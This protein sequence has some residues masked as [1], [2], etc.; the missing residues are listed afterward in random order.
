MSSTAKGVN[1]IYDASGNIA[2]DLDQDGLADDGTTDTNQPDHRYLIEYNDSPSA[3]KLTETGERIV[4]N[5][6]KY[7]PQSD[8][9]YT[10]PDINNVFLAYVAKVRDQNGVPHQVVKPS[11]MAP[12]LLRSPI[13]GVSAPLTFEDTNFNGELDSGEDTNSNGVLDDWCVNPNTAS[14]VMRG[15][16]KHIFVPSSGIPNS[17]SLRYMNDADAVTYIGGTARGFPFHPMAPN[18]NTATGTPGA[19]YLPGRMGPYS[20]LSATFNSDAPIEFDYDNDGD[21]LREAILMDLDFPP[22]KDSSGKLFVPLY[23]VTI[24]DLDALINLNAHGNLAKLLYGPNDE[25]LA[26]VPFSNTSPDPNS[27]TDTLPLGNDNSPTA[28]KFWYLS[29]SNLGLGPSEINPLWALNARFGTDNAPASTVFSQHQLFYG[30]TPRALATPYPA[31]GET[32]NMELAW[33]KLGRLDIDGTGPTIKDVLPGAYGE[34]SRLYNA[35]ATNNLALAGG[36]YLPRPGISLTDDNADIGEGQSIPPF[37]QHP[38]DYTGLGSY[39]TNGKLLNWNTASAPFQWLT[40]NKYGNNINS[41]TGNILWG[42]KAGLMTNSLTQALGDDPNEIPFYTS[43]QYD[44]LFTSDEMLYLSLKNSEIT[45]L[46]APSRLAQLLPFNFAKDSTDNLRGFD[47]RRKFTTDSNDRKSFGL[48]FTT[49]AVNDYSQDF[50]R[51]GGSY[52]GTYRFPPQFGNTATAVARYTTTA[53]AE[54][55]FRPITRTLLEIELNNSRNNNHLQRKLSINHFLK[56]DTNNQI[57]FS[58]L[59]PHPDDPGA[60]TITVASY[61]PTTPAGQEYWARSDRQKM[62]RDIYV[63]LYL[64]GHGDDSKN[65]AATANVNNALYTDDQLREMAQFAVNY[66]D[67]LDRDNVMTRFEYDKDLSD[68]WNLDD[69][70]YGAIE[71]GA[72]PYT[73]AAA[74]YNPSY[75]NDSAIRGE[76]FGIERLDLVLN[77]SLFIA[78]VGGTNYPQTNYDETTDRHFVYAEVVNQGP[79]P[80]TF[81]TK[82]AYQIVLRQEG[83]TPWERAATIKDGTVINSGATVVIGSTDTRTT[84]SAPATFKRSTFAVNSTNSGP[85]VAPPVAPNKPSGSPNPDCDTDLVELALASLP[86]APT[87]MQIL[88]QAGTDVS[89][90]PGAM[91]SA[92]TGA[93]PAGDLTKPIKVLLRRRAHPTRSISTAANDNPWVE[94][95]SIILQPSL[96]IQTF[97]LSGGTSATNIQNQLKT[98]K[99]LERK[100]PLD[101]QSETPFSDSTG[102]LTTLNSLG[103]T[104]SVSLTAFNLWQR[105]FDRDFSSIIDLMHIPVCAPFQFTALSYR[106]QTESPATQMLPGNAV[107]SPKWQSGAPLAQYSINAK[108]AAARFMV[109]ED[110][111]NSTSLVSVNKNNRWHRVLE[112]LEVPTRTNLNLG[113]G[114]ALSIPRVPGRINLNTL[115]HPDNL[116]ALLD[117]STAMSLNLGSSSPPDPEAASLD[118]PS[119]S[120]RD[121]WHQLLRSRDPVDPYAATAGAMIDV[122]LPGLPNPNTIL[123]TPPSTYLPDAKP[124]KS[125]ADVPVTPSP[126]S[127]GQTHPTVSGT[128][129]ATLPLDSA[130]PIGAQRRL[131]EIGSQ[132]EHISSTYDPYVQHRLLSKIVGNSTTRSNCFAIFI[133]VKYFQAAEVNGAVRIAGP[134]NGTPEPEHRGLFVI[135][136]S[137]L[138]A[139]QQSNGPNYNFRAFINYRKTL[140]TQ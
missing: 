90:T 41:A 133:S 132:A 91:L 44:N 136:R 48:P 63:L 110:P 46:N 81:D 129:L 96:G 28:P 80:V 10:Y 107:P 124:F 51:V 40:Y 113:V 84:A 72:T 67:A 24:H 66:V 98:V 18:Y 120:T 43:T 103:K 12:G 140:Q 138:E 26:D 60:A 94:I 127:P 126:A 7:F 32:A 62:A 89:A 20:S 85:P 39:T 97:D 92:F 109:P 86:T 38:L 111:I 68:G 49:R 19:V 35:K 21:G 83:T 54:D 118:D 76:V 34:E 3:P 8:V 77:E 52:T 23:L 88:D 87:T 65:T 112:F 130:Q 99:S 105:H 93:A 27:P 6:S 106:M 102:A 117:D 119:E 17:P 101:S 139:G 64:L 137:K 56:T 82:G 53:L 75:P 9:G 45:R 79:L 5:G 42:Q 116:G 58:Q 128:I 37:F 57:S 123:R 33:S 1:L 61:P 122:P 114:T 74:N 59:T 2:V 47:I 95:D 55:P 30:K 125:L 31:W 71:A 29:Q 15:H 14:M 11:Y 69:D 36:H 13:G 108:T 134:V 135:D 100:Q 78:A 115:R 104:N 121:W 16:H 22:Q 25:T 70:P 131:F 73:A 50:D 4:Y